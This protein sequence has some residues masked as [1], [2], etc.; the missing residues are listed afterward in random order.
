MFHLMESGCAGP[1][2]MTGRQVAWTTPGIDD[3]LGDDPHCRDL[4]T[5]AAKQG[6]LFPLQ[7][8]LRVQSVV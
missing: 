6:P 1:N 8:V 7:R 5:R 4:E 2:V 3:S